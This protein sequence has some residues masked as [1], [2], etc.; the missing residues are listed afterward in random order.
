MIQMQSVTG[1]QEGRRVS[2]STIVP[3]L[4]FFQDA[5]QGRYI[6]C[7]KDGKSPDDQGQD[8]HYVVRCRGNEKKIAVRALDGGSFPMSPNT[9]PI[10]LT[11]SDTSAGDFWAIPLSTSHQNKA[12]ILSLYGM[13]YGFSGFL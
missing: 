8:A 10:D 3:T 13:K 6:D 4:T 11:I 2:L 12:I 1:F 7:Y 9:S 5:L